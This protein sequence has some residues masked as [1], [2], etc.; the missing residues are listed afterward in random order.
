MMHDQRSVPFLRRSGFTLIELVVV[1]GIIGL[2]VGL[3]IPAVLAAR[4]AV[5]RAECAS[6]LRQLGIAVQA[7]EETH[8][9]MPS[10]I[11]SM[12]PMRGFFHKK[13]TVFTA[14]LPYL[15]QGSLYAAINFESPLE[16]PAYFGWDDR[17]LSNETALRTKVELFLCPADASSG[18]P[19]LM[20]GI[21][22]RT[23]QGAL[24]NSGTPRT[25][26]QLGP[27]SDNWWPCRTSQIKD[28]LSNTIA[29]SE[30]LRSES[31][32]D[33]IVG[34]TIVVHR[35]A[36]SPD[37]PF[38]ACTAHL[39]EG[40]GGIYNFS[41]LSWMI[42]GMSSS[43]YNHVLTPN[44]ADADCLWRS[45]PAPG[46]VAAR[47]EHR[48]GVNALAVDGSVRFVSNGIDEDVWIA[49][50]TRAGGEVLPQ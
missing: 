37:R 16:N 10:I 19:S 26:G 3:L 12:G 8:G 23:N 47:G 17:M 7:Y 30:G 45:N 9:V 49:L 44:A 40:T 2:L 24:R 5:R 32:A 39:S 46:Y 22:Y 6:N 28:G 42:G 11:Q 33:R 25:R 20:A 14:I 27:F 41:G 31:L 15:D 35:D 13:Y 21:N 4:S 48:G 34:R 36:L 38:S 50:G 29:V 18:P 1:I 43:S